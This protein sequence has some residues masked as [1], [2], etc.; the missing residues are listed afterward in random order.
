MSLFRKKLT[1]LARTDD[2]LD[3]A[4]EPIKSVEGPLARGV[5]GSLPPENSI[6]RGLG[7]P[8]I[9]R[10]AGYG[11]SECSQCISQISAVH[12]AMFLRPHACLGNTF[13]MGKDRNFASLNPCRIRHI[14]QSPETS[15]SRGMR[16]LSVVLLFLVSG[17]AH[18]TQADWQAVA[19]GFNQRPSP[20]R[21][22][23]P[24]QRMEPVQNCYTTQVG[25][26]GSGTY[27]TN[28][29]KY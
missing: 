19:D 23:R 9:D 26:G 22:Q 10:E 4:T 2:R 6:E 13:F 16:T 24:L 25:L 27:A 5:L 15:H 28:C 21:Y 29:T 3:L 18:M 8:R 17:C 11:P 14:P 12:M 1:R 7:H 20:A